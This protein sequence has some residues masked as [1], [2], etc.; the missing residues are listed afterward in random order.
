MCFKQLKIRRLL[1][2]L[3]MLAIVFASEAQNKKFKL[4]LNSAIYIFNNKGDYL[5]EF[6]PKGIYELEFEYNNDGLTIHSPV[7]GSLKMSNNFI[8]RETKVLNS[9][10]DLIRYVLKD[11]NSANKGLGIHTKGFSYFKGK[12]GNNGY[13]GDLAIWFNGNMYMLEDCDFVNCYDYEG[14]TK[15]LDTTVENDPLIKF[16]RSISGKKQSPKNNNSSTKSSP[17]PK[18]GEIKLL[19]HN[20]ERVWNVDSQ[21]YMVLESVDAYPFCVKTGSDNH[22]YILNCCIG[23]TIKPSNK[24]NINWTTRKG[25]ISISLPTQTGVSVG[26]NDEIICWEDSENPLEIK[27]TMFIWSQSTGKLQCI[28]TIEF[29]FGSRIIENMYY[30]VTTDTSAWSKIR[31]MLLYNLPFCGNRIN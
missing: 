3:G 31:P 23:S 2:V 15:L 12:S 14:V 25:A 10:E 28:Q 9:N 30:F 11:G 19:G 17:T 16:M 1:F 26:N 21:S 27:K 24:S 18:Y 4:V 6:A 8:Y 7:I 5:G 20:Y 22:I 29:N 13:S